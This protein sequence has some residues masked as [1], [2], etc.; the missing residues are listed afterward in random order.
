M[1]LVPTRFMLLSVSGTQGQHM[2]VEDTLKD[3]WAT[4]PRRPRR[5]RKLAGVAAAIGIR[6]RIDPVIVRVGFVVATFYGGAGILIYLLGWLFFP[7]QDDEAAPLESM[8]RHRHSSMSGAFTVLLCLALIPAIWLLTDNEFSGYAGLLIVLGLLF[9]LHRT[10]GHLGRTVR[11]STPP[12]PPAPEPTSFYPLYPP[13]YEPAAAAT[14]A[15]PAPTTPPAW[16]PLGAAPFAWDLPEPSPP[17]PEPPQPRRKS[18]A[19]LFTVGAALVTI[20]VLAVVY[21]YAGGWL[22]PHHF[23]GIILAVIGLGLVFGAFVGG[24]R[25]LIGLAVPLSVIGIGM[26]VIAPEGWHGAGEVNEHPTA[27]SEVHKSYRLSVGTVSLDLTGLPSTGE[28]KT[29]VKID[30]AG[31]VRITVP[32]SADVQVQCQANAGDLHCLG[33]NASGTN[34]D[35]GEFTD[36]GPDGEGGLQIELDIEV[37]A[38]NVEVNRG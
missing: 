36:P 8:V 6:Y 16:D 33:H 26:T 31:E 13:P 10:R 22:T 9:L 30:A 29:K 34:V 32:P 19:G 37:G 28:L 14:S 1:R 25:G 24:G 4:R 3:F 23:I 17:A 21:P 35:T 38:G 15:E 7:E 11:P 18:K 2:A 27:I 20:G 12:P 5:G